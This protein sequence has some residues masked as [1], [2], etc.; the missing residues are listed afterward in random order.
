MGQTYLAGGDPLA[1]TR[2]WQDVLAAIVASKPE[3]SDTHYRW[4]TASKDTAFYELLWHTGASQTDAACLTVEDINWNTRTISY[5][6]KKLKSRAGIK[7]ALICFGDEV[8]AILQRRPQSG[9]L[10]PYLRTV[11]PSDRATEFKQRC[12]GLKIRG[13]IGGLACLAGIKSV[14][15]ASGGKGGLTTEHASQGTSRFLSPDLW[16]ARLNR[17]GR[18]FNESHVIR[19]QANANIFGPCLCIGW[20]RMTFDRMRPVFDRAIRRQIGCWNNDNQGVGRQDT[21]LPWIAVNRLAGGSG[22]LHVRASGLFCWFSSNNC[23][24]FIVGWHRSSAGRARFHPGS[25]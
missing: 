10:F 15:R 6:R 2:T 16:S 21:P 14:G 23:S 20:P 9:P 7:P 3:D 22:H 5:C 1:L 13:V 11:R 12:E 4:N 19:A 18:H 8:A 24:P 17:V 25:R